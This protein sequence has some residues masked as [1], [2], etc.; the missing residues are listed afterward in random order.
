MKITHERGMR[1]PASEVRAMNSTYIHIKTGKVYIQT[2]FPTGSEWKEELI[3]DAE[4][5]AQGKIPAAASTLAETLVAGNLSGANPILMENQDIY[6]NGFLGTGDLGINFSEGGDSYAYYG[7]YEPSWRLGYNTGMFVDEFTYTAIYTDDWN[8]S[9]ELY[10]DT[11]W[12]QANSG[13]SMQLKG[14]VNDNEWLVSAASGAGYTIL[15]AGSG[16]NHNLATNFGAAQIGGV[17]LSA[18]TN[19][20]IYQKAGEIGPIGMIISSNDCELGYTAQTG[21]TPRYNTIISSKGSDIKGTGTFAEVSYNAII[22]SKDTNIVRSEST[23]ILASDK[24]LVA[25]DLTVEDQN[26]LVVLAHQGGTFGAGTWL[27]WSTVVENLYVDGK[28]MFN[29]TL[30]IEGF[31][32][33]P[34]VV[35]DPISPLDGDIWIKDNFGTTT[36]NVRVN[37]V[38]KS[39]TLT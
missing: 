23:V 32:N 21:L 39:V 13:I 31:A 17:V 7:V 33:A 28:A 10:E 19:S 12:M 11:I 3:G 1:S 15:K 30:N 35:S 4:D 24:G 14:G 34:I 37:G 5:I 36:L 18:S 25:T 22:A 9:M 27:E 2:A 20:T 16:A 29:T 8:V 26:H 6:N 38:T